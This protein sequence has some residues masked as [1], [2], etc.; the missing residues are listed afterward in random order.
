MNTYKSFLIKQYTVKTSFL[1]KQQ[2]TI[3]GT[4]EYKRTTLPEKFFDQFV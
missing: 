2:K 1:M 4:K 3:H